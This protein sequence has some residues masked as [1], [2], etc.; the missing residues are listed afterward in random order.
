MKHL[1]L[2]GNNLTLDDIRDVMLCDVRIS[3]APKAIANIKKSRAV[4]DRALHRGDVVSVEMIEML[5][6]MF[7]KGVYPVVP[8]QG[9]AGASGDLAPLAHIGAAMLGVGEVFYN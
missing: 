4:V 7:N 3:L 2:T 9:S 5:I 6:N 8:E 1:I